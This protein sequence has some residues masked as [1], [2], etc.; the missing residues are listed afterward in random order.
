MVDVTRP[1]SVSQAAIWATGYDIMWCDE[2][3][4]ARALSPTRREDL[5][6]PLPRSA[7]V[8]GHWTGATCGIHA[9]DAVDFRNGAFD[10]PGRVLGQDVLQRTAPHPLSLLPSPLICGIPVP[11]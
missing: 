5:A 3:H 6:I 10:H 1:S 2:P 11:T 8:R 9:E 4:A 7:A